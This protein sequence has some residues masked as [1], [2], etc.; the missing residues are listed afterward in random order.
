MLV[1]DPAKDIRSFRVATS[2]TLGTKRGR[3][4]GAFIDSVL[5]AVD[6]FYARGPRRPQGVVG[7]A[8][9]AAAGLPHRHP[10]YRAH[11]PSLP[12]VYGYF[13]A[14]RPWRR[15]GREHRPKRQPY[16]RRRNG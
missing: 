11:Q 5:A 3:G 6:S 14:G 9:E 2:S 16:R 10:R 4:R 12:G 15:R 1:T 7:R 13:V 8:T